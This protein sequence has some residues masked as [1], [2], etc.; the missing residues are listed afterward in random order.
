MSC[1]TATMDYKFISTNPN[2]RRRAV[3][4]LFFV[5]FF[6]TKAC[7]PL[8]TYRSFSFVLQSL[9]PHYRSEKRK[10]CTT[11]SMEV[12]NRLNTKWYF[13]AKMHVLKFGQFASLFLLK[14]PKLFGIC[15]LKWSLL[16][17]VAI[18]LSN[19]STT[20]I[21]FQFVIGFR[22]SKFQFNVIPEMQSEGQY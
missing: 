10:K 13:L 18:S 21:N 9:V 12:E 3:P 1:L 7:F 15:I 20:E 17:H 19:L 16:Y 2:D 6:K 14:Y 4:L 11:F 5:N 22:S 8:E